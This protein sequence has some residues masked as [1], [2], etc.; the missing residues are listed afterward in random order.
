MTKKKTK[1]SHLGEPILI[2]Q[3]GVSDIEYDDLRFLFDHF[4]KLIINNFFN[5]FFPIFQSYLLFF[6]SLIFLHFFFY[7]K[8]F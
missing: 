6:I 2:K 5:I 1:S 7:V 4:E 8:Q 3:K